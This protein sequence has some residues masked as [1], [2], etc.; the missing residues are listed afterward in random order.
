MDNFLGN[1]VWIHLEGNGMVV[2]T[3]PV[4]GED[5]LKIVRGSKHL[6]MT[7]SQVA[8]QTG[9]HNRTVASRLRELAKQGLVARRLRPRGQGHI[10]V[11]LDA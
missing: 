9:I 2:M 8:L 11:A 6:G 7:V 4:S 5:V 3:K 10:W 1:I